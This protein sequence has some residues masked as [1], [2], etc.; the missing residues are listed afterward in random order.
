MG[1]PGSSSTAAQQFEI[2]A[3]AA[4]CLPDPTLIFQCR[5]EAFQM[6]P[7]LGLQSR[8]ILKDCDRLVCFALPLEGMGQLMGR[9]GLERPRRRVIADRLL[10]PRQRL[11]R[12]CQFEIDPDILGMT[13][14]GVAEYRFGGRAV[15][16]GEELR[17]QLTEANGRQLA[18]SRLSGEFFENLE[19]FLASWPRPRRGAG[20][21][22]GRGRQGWRSL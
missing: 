19:F 21:A 2:A 10:A 4:S 6:P 16:E 14:L 13:P 17:T 1:E 20:C 22:R 7:L 3:S 12:S 9:R 15:T 18:D 5:A 11:E 8:Q